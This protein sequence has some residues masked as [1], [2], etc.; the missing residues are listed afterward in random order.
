V[1]DN[2]TFQESKVI[3]YINQNKRVVSKEVETLL[4]LK[5]SRTREL[6][7]SMVDRGLIKRLGRGRSTYYI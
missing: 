4:N 3:Q 5:E 2:L 7:K 6:L 1:S